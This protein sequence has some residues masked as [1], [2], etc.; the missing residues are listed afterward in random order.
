MSYIKK[1]DDDAICYDI[2]MNVERLAPDWTVPEEVLS[3]S[4]YKKICM[5]CENHKE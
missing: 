3:V 2:H 4:K 5:K 1:T